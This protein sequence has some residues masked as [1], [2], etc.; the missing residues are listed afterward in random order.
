MKIFNKYTRSAGQHFGSLTKTALKRAAIAATIAFPLFVAEANAATA[1]ACPLGKV[2]QERCAYVVSWARP[3]M[4]LGGQTLLNLPAAV[5]VEIFSLHGYLG[6]LAKS[7]F[8]A[9]GKGAVFSLTM[10][11]EGF[12]D[13]VR[14]GQSVTGVS[15]TGAMYDWGKLGSISAEFW[16]RLEKRGLF[17][18]SSWF[19]GYVVMVGRHP[20]LPPN[21]AEV[22]SVI[23]ST[24]AA[25]KSAETSASKFPAGESDRSRQ[26]S[27]RMPSRNS[28]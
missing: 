28:Y 4:S 3:N 27:G 26:G 25:I 19:G 20:A 10:P 9:E 11:P 18:G 15:A 21:D 14:A 5:I 1:H 7:S 8:D 16:V 2:V 17:A 24:V 6:N 12:A 23:E 22:A 13:Y